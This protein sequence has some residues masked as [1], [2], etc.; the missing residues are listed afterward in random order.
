VLNE[1]FQLLI[2]QKAALESLLQLSIEERHVI[3]RNESDKLEDIV[4][5]QL[6]ELSKLGGIEK[7]RAALHPTISKELGIPES[8]ITISAIAARAEPD[9]RETIKK[10]QSE[11]TQLINRHKELNMENRELI[12]THQEYSE[13]ILGLL[14]GSEDPLN[15]FYGV[16]GKA[17]LEKKKTTGFFDGTA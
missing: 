2:E 4:R 12:K 14:M 15:N 13:S 10:L 17:A 9:E 6:K 16:D 7:K 8:D 5:L 3:I 11:L 1:L